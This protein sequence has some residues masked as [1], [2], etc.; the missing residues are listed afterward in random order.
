MAKDGNQPRLA[1]LTLDN[2]NP[3]Q[4]AV[5]EKMLSGP[6]KGMKGPFSALLRHP[7]LCDK[8][9]ELGAVV[10]FKNSIPTALKEMAIIMAG[11]HWTASYEFQA[12][13]RMALDAGV[14]EAICDSIAAG[15]RPARLSADEA[16]VYD[17][18]SE[19]LATGSV[20]DK[21]YNT[22]L[23]RWGE[24]GVVD[25]TATVGY[26]CIASF[27]LNVSRHPMPDGAEPLKPL[28]RA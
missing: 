5:A 22:V 25:L 7:E 21:A 17:F 28:P 24:K 2:M 14:S 1:L 10:R 6:R 26:Y 16:A 12:H 19:L 20:G 27:I 3:E 13:R 18:C 23:E 15:Q 11:R 8:V 9:Q 4:R